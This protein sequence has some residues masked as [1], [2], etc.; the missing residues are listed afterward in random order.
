MEL[1]TANLATLRHALQ[2]CRE[3][4]IGLYRIPSKIFPFS[5]E[6]LGIALL[7]GMGKVL[8]ALG[9]EATH[10][11]LRL[12]MHPNQFVVLNSEQPHVIVNSLK[13]LAAHARVLDA[14][15][16][17]R[18]PWATIEIH[19]GKRG[20]KQALI[21]A[22]RRLPVPVR[23]RLALENDESHYSAGDILDV[24]RQSG[25][26]MVFD[27]HHHVC[28]E[29]LESYEDPSI[30]ALTAA[31]ATTWPDPAWQLVHISNGRDSF[32]DRRHAD[33]VTRVPSAYARVP[34]IEVEAKAK[35]QAIARLRDEWLPRPVRA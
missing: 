20:R 24:C 19:G 6:P 18:S 10:M 2:F 8:A 4:R 32:T 17:P 15:K 23:R 14:L 25:V 27:A 9:R 30:A 7:A 28:F 13:I 22:V 3:Q 11:G 31:A 26:P 16:Q 21:D 29:A 12:V 33:E 1:Y 34:W 35:E 5:D